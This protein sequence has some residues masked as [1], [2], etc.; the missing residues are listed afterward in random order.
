MLLTLW[1]T[2]VVL[3]GILAVGVP[4]VWLLD[5]RRPL[6]E[7]NWVEAPFVGAAA[8]ILV[9]QNLVY[10]D[11]PVC[12]TF[13][14]VWAGAAAGWLWFWRSGQARVSFARCPRYLFLAALAVYA[15]Q[16][17]GL[18]LVGV[19][20]YLG[21]MWGDQSNYTMI[22][23]FLARER[24]SLTLA[25]SG[26]RPWL[27]LVNI[28]LKS[29]RIGQSV[30]HAFFAQSA[31]CEARM[32]F[33][34]TILLCPTLT[35]LAVYA[36]ARACGVGRAWSTLTGAAA[37][38]LPALALLH[39]ESFLSHAVA[40]PFLLYLPAGMCHLVRRPSWRRLV[41]PCLVLA[42]AVSIYGEFFPI[43]MGLLVVMGLVGS[44]GPRGAKVF[45][46]AALLLASPLL[47]NPMYA[48]YLANILKRLD[49]PAPVLQ[50]IY[51]WALKTE[52]FA[53]L[54]LG[55]F[56]D[57]PPGKKRLVVR[58]FGLAATFLGYLGLAGAF[59]AA[60][61]AVPRSWRSLRSR[62]AF[63]LLCGVLA[64][65]LLPAVVLARDDDH[66]YQFY[67]LMLSVSPLLAL[68]LALLARRAGGPGYPLP[69]AG[70][71]VRL[72]PLPGAALLGAALAAGVV[73]TGHMAYQSAQR[74]PV[75]RVPLRCLMD[76]DVKQ[77]QRNLE[78][79]RGQDLL[80]ACSEVPEDANG[81]YS[82]WL[83]YYARRNRVRCAGP[84][85]FGGYYEGVPQAK[86]Y[87][88]AGA[89][90]LAPGAVVLLC[91]K[92][93][94]DESGLGDVELV[95]RAGAYALLR[96]GAGAWAVPVRWACP[97]GM[98][99]GGPDIPA[100]WMGGGDTRVEFLASCPGSVRIK[101]ALVAGPSLPPGA[102]RRITVETDR[103]HRSELVVRG[104]EEVIEVPVGRGK[105]VVLMRACDVPLPGPLPNGD[106]RPLLWNVWLRGMKYEPAGGG[107]DSPA[108]PSG[109]AGGPVAA[110]GR[111]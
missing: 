4:A 27:Y 103:G 6:R 82:G 108:S 64:L 34:P 91:R 14:L 102:G 22:A 13:L 42:A 85:L 88:G 17:L 79:M 73:A 71:R 93:Y 31:G 77:V 56:A 10:L 67:K 23:E 105:T 44:A 81:F 18:V 9:L 104:A 28:V 100:F 62:A 110:A 63:A 99:E 60:A 87:L 3:G 39:L 24:F 94:G 38:L 109:A 11:V 65:A 58:A 7:V 69:G 52:G 47:L 106:P 98:G 90:A 1:C 5:G 25:E 78:K 54:W 95:W 70:A 84:W 75:T 59:V 83:S 49:P 29:E 96:A 74:L 46:C 8:A 86:W 48:P 45:A 72:L 40:T 41:P 55:D 66:P 32:L 68:G 43:A 37:G 12:K 33:E 15:T 50:G 21:R 80:I 20:W 89:G 97:N 19:R 2:V 92:W 51:P 61:Y 30:L 36:L 57:F 111:D 26:G 101:A 16:G 107:A 35:V 53:R 76:P